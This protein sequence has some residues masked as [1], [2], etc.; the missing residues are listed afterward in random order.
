MADGRWGDAELGR[1]FLEAQ[2][3]RGGLKRA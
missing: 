2:V 1:S 3:P